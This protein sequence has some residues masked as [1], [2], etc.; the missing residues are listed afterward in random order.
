MILREESQANM[1][2][3]FGIPGTTP[4]QEVLRSISRMC[5]VR[6]RVH[7]LFNSPVKRCGFHLSGGRN[8]RVPACKGNRWLDWGKDRANFRPQPPP[9]SRLNLT[10]PRSEWARAQRLTFTVVQRDGKRWCCTLM[11]KNSHVPPRLH[12]G[13]RFRGRP[14]E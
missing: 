4:N 3:L 13:Q 6:E 9:L 1:M 14:R 5:A 10:S 7:N 12:N 2:L 8:G 11:A